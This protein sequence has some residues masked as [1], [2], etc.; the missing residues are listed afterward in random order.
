MHGKAQAERLQAMIFP[1]VLDANKIVIGVIYLAAYTLLDWLSFIEPYAH[2][3]ITPWNPG[4]GLSFVL[5]LV[6]GRRMIPF[7]LISPLFADIAQRHF[8]LPWSF[9][10]L[11][12][13]VVGGGYSLAALYL[14]R[15]RVGFD[16][17]L[18]SMRDL[19]SLMLVAFLSAALIAAAYVG[20]TIAAG[21][22]PA[23]DF[24]AAASMQT[25]RMALRP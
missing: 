2:L 24:T 19:L 23:G 6:F 25:A 5:L 3:S 18:S 21:L 7:V 4:T 22:L 16:P 20:L 14:M 12:S 9:E 15:P 10:I 1:R 8:T 13:L 17:T 11:T